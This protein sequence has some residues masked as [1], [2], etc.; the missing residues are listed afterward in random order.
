M[1]PK[2]NLICW[3]TDS[4]RPAMN[5]VQISRKDLRATNAHVLAIVP[6]EKTALADCDLPEEPVYLHHKSYELL[7]KPSIIKIVFDAGKEG[8]T[9]YHKNQPATFVPLTPMGERYPDFEPLIPRLSDITPLENISLNPKLL[10]DLATAIAEP[11]QKNLNVIL[12]FVAKNSTILVR[13]AES[14]MDAKAILMPVYFEK[15]TW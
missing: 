13:S 12:G 2:L 9:A 3:K 5:H 4:L 8:F 7:T 1:L 11:G 15:F 10:M 14:S 6:T